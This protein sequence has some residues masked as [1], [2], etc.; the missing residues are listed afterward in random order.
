[1]KF[2]IP[3]STQNEDMTRQILLHKTI[4]NRKV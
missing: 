4:T 3:E 1:M 2:D